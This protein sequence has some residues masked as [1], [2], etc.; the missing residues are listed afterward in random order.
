MLELKND[1]CISK[2]NGIIIQ[3]FIIVVEILVIKMF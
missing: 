3:K 2:I 1:K